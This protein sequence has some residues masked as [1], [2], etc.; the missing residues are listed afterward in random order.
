MWLPRSIKESLRS[1]LLFMDWED[2]GPPFSYAQEVPCEV[3]FLVVVA[4]EAGTC[5]AHQDRR[6]KMF[7][8][9]SLQGVSRE[10][11]K[12]NLRKASAGAG[13]SLNSQVAM[14]MRKTGSLVSR[15]RRLGIGVSFNTMAW[16]GGFV[17][18][19]SIRT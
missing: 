19:N 18:G 5:M 10:R 8:R 12:F 6:D 3:V 16:E 7:L 4:S 14:G 1:R 2:V 9:K 15:L 13:L 11:E 17:S